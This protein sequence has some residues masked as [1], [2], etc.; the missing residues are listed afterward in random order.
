MSHPRFDYRK[1]NIYG[2]NVY[3]PKNKKKTTN[4]TTFPK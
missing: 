3:C 2:R 4:L 1:M